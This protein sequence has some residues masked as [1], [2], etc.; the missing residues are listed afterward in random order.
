[1]HSW[2]KALFGFVCCMFL[3]AP[4]MAQS[5]TDSADN[6]NN[7]GDPAAGRVAFNS[8]V[9]CH[10]IPN[11]HYGYQHFN[12][13]K[14]GGQHYEYLLS[15]LGEYAAGKR[16]NQTMHAQASSLSEQDLKNLA[17]YLSQPQS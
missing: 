11:Y 9:G 1:M 13:P 4:A 2:R 7:K 12:V 16:K 3:L 15:A 14:L 10:G 8:C 17:A 6:S 5:D